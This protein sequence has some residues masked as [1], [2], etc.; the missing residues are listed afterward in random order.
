MSGFVLGLDEDDGDVIVTAG[1]CKVTANQKTRVWGLVTW[2][3]PR[4]KN[5]QDNEVEV[6]QSVYV[7]VQYKCEGSTGKVNGKCNNNRCKKTAMVFERVPA[8]GQPG[9]GRFARHCPLLQVRNFIELYNTTKYQSIPQIHGHWRLCW[10]R[11]CW[12]LLLLVPDRSHWPPDVLLAADRVAVLQLPR[13]V[14]VIF[15]RS[16]SKLLS[17]WTPPCCRQVRELWILSKG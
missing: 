7:Y 14:Q 5:K 8:V 2:S 9:D 13:T 1:L 10:Q 15:R 12:S 6:N 3:G 11:H 16:V 4:N 17:Y